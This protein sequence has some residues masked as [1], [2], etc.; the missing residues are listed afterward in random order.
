VRTGTERRQAVLD[1]LGGRAD[2]D[3][4]RREAVIAAVLAGDLP[5][6]AATVDRLVTEYAVPRR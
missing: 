6:D 5:V 2:E 3:A 1:L 4:D